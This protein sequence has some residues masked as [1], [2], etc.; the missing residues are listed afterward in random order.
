MTIWP[1]FLPSRPSHEVCV[2]ILIHHIKLD[3]RPQSQEV[4]WRHAWTRKFPNISSV[5]YCTRLVFAFLTLSLLF[6]PLFSC[7]SSRDGVC[8]DPR[9]GSNYCA[10]GTDCQVPL[11]PALHSWAAH[12][13]CAKRTSLAS[14]KRLS[15]TPDN[16]LSTTSHS[17]TALPTASFLSLPSSLSFSLRTVDQSERITSP[18]RMT[19]VED[20]GTMMMT[21]GP[22]TTTTS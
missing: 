20:G 11:L 16:D 6:Y 13:D 10:I 9:G 14:W 5:L 12:W 19:M 21:T 4:G 2:Q 15:F 17:S 22:S 18:K 7:I 8:D 3:N 1:F